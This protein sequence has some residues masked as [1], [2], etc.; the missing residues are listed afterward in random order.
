[1]E[2]M[3]KG[4]K[5]DGSSCGN[6]AMKG[7]LVCRMHG[8][9]SPQAK[10]AAER[11]LALQAIDAD[12]ESWGLGGTDVDPGET[13]L[14]LLA[15]AR[16]RAQVYAAEVS[17]VVTEH[18]LQEALVGETLIVDP[19]NGRLHK[20]GEYIRGL[21]ALENQE[22][23]RAAK[24][25]DLAIRAGLAERQVRLAEKQGA[26]IEQ[27]LMLVFEDIGLSAEQR[28]AAPDAIRRALT[29]VA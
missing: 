9:A 25:S 21:A 20:V 11:R 26:L 16:A 4:H 5:R 1:V 7:Q 12:I 27:V 29:A 6:K 8:G 17:R 14:R 19:N 28:R 10:A 13:L 24:Y 3:C 15:Q 22:R 2:R 23:D 18:G